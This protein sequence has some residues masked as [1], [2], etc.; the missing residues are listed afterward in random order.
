MYEKPLIEMRCYR[1]HAGKAQTFEKLMQEQSLPLLRS[2]GCEVVYAG[3]SLD[4]PEHYVLIRAYQDLADREQSQQAFYS[5][6][7][8]REGPR[9]AILDCIES[10]VDFLQQRSVLTNIFTKENHE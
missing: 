10:S 3:A 8:W 9:A 1:L 6:A 4:K 7:A 2:S 5:S